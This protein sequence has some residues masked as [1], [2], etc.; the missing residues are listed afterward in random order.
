MR[1]FDTTYRLALLEPGKKDLGELKKALAVYVKYTASPEKTAT[2]E[3][4]DWFD[5]YNREFDDI[6]M[7]FAFYRNDELIGYAE[8]VFFM[9]DK[10]VFLDYMT[11]HE[12]YEKN[13]VF[14][15]FFEQI[16][17][18]LDS[19]EREYT[20][21]VTEITY[22]A[23]HSTPNKENR[24]W[25]SLLKMQGF[26]EIHA[27]Y[28]HPRLGE[29]NFESELPG[30]LMLYSRDEIK[31]LRPTTYVA[32]A[33]SVYKKHYLRWYRPYL[34]D[35]GAAYEK[36]LN[37]YLKEIRRS[38]QGSDSI[39]I[40]GYSEIL[41]AAPIVN[42]QQ[43]IRIFRTIIPVTLVIVA[44][45]MVITIATAQLSL[46]M[47]VVIPAFLITLIVFFAAISIYSKEVREVLTQ[48]LKAV[49]SFGSK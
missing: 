3:I 13:N 14:Y 20:Y 49:I 26:H 33:E 29:K 27:K 48:L 15:E 2:N 31:S 17:A 4:E 5:L 41:K 47:A 12:K 11:L 7:L 28:F 9:D 30:E 19:L 24:L 8:L 46:P 6:L 35:K 40:N 22:D 23:H 42:A 39:K 18:Y 37:G 32:L 34:K 45:S 1:T 43:D 38:L 36:V 21:I 16:Q 25:I 10:F 44:I